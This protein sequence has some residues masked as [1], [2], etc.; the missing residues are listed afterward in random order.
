[1]SA[2]LSGQAAAAPSYVK[3]K[4]LVAWVADV[5]RLTQPDRVVWS[6][7]SQAEYDRLCE[8]MVQS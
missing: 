1:M 8:E 5:A 3:N 2:V 4:K 6:D 7:G